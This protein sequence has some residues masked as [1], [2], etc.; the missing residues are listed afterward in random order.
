MDLST[1][2]S[3]IK[4]KSLESLYIFTGSDS[5]VMK[6][7]IEQMAKVNNSSVK[8]LDSITDLAKKAYNSSFV[9]TH[10][11]CILYEDKEFIQNDTIRAKILQN[12]AFNNT[13]LIFIYSSIDK[14]SK[15]YK[16]YQDNIVDFQPLSADILTKY[17]QRRIALSDSKCK[18]LIEVCEGN[19]SQ[20][21]LE[22]DKIISYGSATDDTNYNKILEYLLDVGVIH[23]PAKDAVF[24]FVHAV[25]T[26]RD[27]QALEL[28]ENCRGVNEATLVILA[29]LYNS[30]KQLF[31]VQSY[32]GSGKYTDV[33]GL[34]PFQVKLARGRVGYNSNDHLKSFMK[35]IRS[36]EKGIKCGDIEEQFAVEYLLIKFWTEV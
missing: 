32:T 1:L 35:S 15:L 11:I 34:T 4:N 9:K 27:K 29:N 5:G 25:L 30:T 23:I 24:D 8:I 21:M 10:E 12:N 16:S 26:N 18:E 2:K 36:V 22:V 33:T 14:R 31:Q 28:L 7:Y 6:I 19:Y 20:I 17:I 13:V 3:H